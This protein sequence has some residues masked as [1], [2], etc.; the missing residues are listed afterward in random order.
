VIAERARPLPA[1]TNNIAEYEGLITALELAADHD[2]RD[3]EVF[4]DS[5]LIVNQVQE[6]WDIKE[7]TLLP[8]RER[9]WKAG[10][11][12]ANLKISWVPR[13]KN[14]RVDALCTETLNTH[15]PK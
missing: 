5:Q 11:E 10:L 6:I 1:G 8:L 2:V 12:F 3:L 14:R 15:Y 13:E 9:A 4:S 7:P